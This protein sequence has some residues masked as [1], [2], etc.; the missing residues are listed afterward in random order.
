MGLLSNK[1]NKVAI[2]G[3]GLMGSGIA[4]VFILSNYHV[5]LKEV[6]EVFL[7]A[8]IEKVKGEFLFFL[9]FSQVKALSELSLLK[10][11][12]VVDFIFLFSQFAV[13]CQERKIFSREA[14]DSALSSEGCA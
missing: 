5:I 13:S 6:N 12:T 4:T 11:I 14:Q 1:I 2:I 9:C 10:G 7:S 3:G 8:G